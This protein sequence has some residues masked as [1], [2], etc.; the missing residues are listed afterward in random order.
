MTYAT[1]SECLHSLE[2]LT[3]GSSR[4]PASLNRGKQL[5]QCLYINSCDRMVS[6]A[7]QARLVQP[8]LI[9]GDVS[10]QAIVEAF[11][12]KPRTATLSVG[13]LPPSQPVRPRQSH[14]RMVPIQERHKLQHCCIICRNPRT[15][16]QRQED[17]AV[18][19]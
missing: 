8:A 9:C 12:I 11:V 18:T 7:S 17:I 2:H 4:V 13:P 14:E 16:Q 3:R 5:P 19:S 15:S 10:P 6:H 1:M